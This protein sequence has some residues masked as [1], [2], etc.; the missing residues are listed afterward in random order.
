MKRVFMS[1]ILLTLWS[2]PVISSSTDSAGEIV[3]SQ[4]IVAFDLAGKTYEPVI[5]KPP[6]FKS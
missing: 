2:T 5:I 4:E 1:L 3:F 6:E